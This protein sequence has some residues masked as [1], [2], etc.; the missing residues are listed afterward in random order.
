MNIQKIIQSL[1]D[2]GASQQEIAEFSG[3]TQGRISQLLKDG[4]SCSWDAGKR[5]EE[6]LAIK[7]SK[8]AA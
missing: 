6:L 8:D 4:G 7:S 1:T 2:L 3:L 5:L